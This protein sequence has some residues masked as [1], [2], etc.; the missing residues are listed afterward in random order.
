MLEIWD[1]LSAA[2]CVAV[3]PGLPLPFIAP[4]WLLVSA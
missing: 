1:V 4:I 3:S 2:I